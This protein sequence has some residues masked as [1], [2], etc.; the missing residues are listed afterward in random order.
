[1]VKIN[2]IST[3]VKNLDMESKEIT[4]LSEKQKSEITRIKEVNTFGSKYDQ[5]KQERE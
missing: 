2:H 5:L 1:M 4:N 3:F